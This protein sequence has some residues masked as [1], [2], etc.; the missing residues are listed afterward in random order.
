VPDEV[1]PALSDGAPVVVWEEALAERASVAI[2]RDEGVEV[3]GVV[4]DGSLDLTPMEEAPK[5]RTVGGRFTAFRAPG[6]GVTLT[7]TGGKAARAAIVVAVADGHGG[8]GAHLDTRDRPGAPPGWSWKV[9]RKRIETVAFADVAPLSWGGGAYH[10][11]IGWEGRGDDH[12]AAVVDMLV[13]SR[14]AGVAEHAH[15]HEWEVLAVLEGDG[16]IVRRPQ[17]VPERVE[18]HPGSIL[19]LAA[20]V[21]HAWQP[22]GKEP[23]VAIQVY[24]PPGPEQR[25]KKLAGKAP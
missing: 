3:M 5:A 17:G 1:R 14:D 22:S 15:D 8:L 19:T 10:A 23:L 4:L 7:G 25:Y 11:R 16:A 13:F 18:A 21:R 2:P 24:A 9:R 20:G 6:G 12:P